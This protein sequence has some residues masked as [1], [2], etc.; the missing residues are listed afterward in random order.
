[1]TTACRPTLRCI[2]EDLDQDWDNVEQFRAVKDRN[3]GSLGVTLPD[4]AHPVIR[5][6]R[7]LYTSASSGDVQREGISGLT[8]PMFYKLKSGRWRGAVYVAPDGTPWLCAAGLRREN[9]TA[10]FYAW[11]MD[12]VRNAGPGGFLPTEADLT[13]AKRERTQAQLEEWEKSLHRDGQVALRTAA[14]S[15]GA[16]EVPVTSI[17]TGATIA[18]ARVIVEQID[19]DQDSLTEVILEFVD[20]DWSAISYVERAQEVLMLSICDEPTAW[21]AGHNADSQIYS[22]QSGT[23]LQFLLDVLPDV[24]RAGLPAEPQLSHLAKKDLLVGSAVN[25]EAVVTLCGAWLVQSR[26]AETLPTCSE[27]AEIHAGLPQSP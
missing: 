14:D 2:A 22:L 20:I 27:C 16:A 7:D 5:H 23:G 19:D 1:M 9:E 26:D 4:L 12:R 15:A 25:G 11:F 6:A 18:T 24:S 10:D 21:T 8:D 3:V 17:K 13:Y